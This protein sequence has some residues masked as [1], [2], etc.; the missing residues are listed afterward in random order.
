MCFG[1]FKDSGCDF[2]RS[3]L[4]YIFFSK[5]S[6]IHYIIVNDTYLLICTYRT[7]SIETLYFISRTHTSNTSTNDDVSVLSPMVTLFSE[8]R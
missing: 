5:F 3:E 7:V 1:L 4:I 8:L 2:K 6:W